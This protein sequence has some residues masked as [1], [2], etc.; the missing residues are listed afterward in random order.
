MGR[1]NPTLL[2]AFVLGAGIALLGTSLQAQQG[3]VETP[4][5]EQ[6]YLI[7]QPLAQFP[8]KSVVVFTGQFAPGASTPLH[9]HPGTE[10]LYVLEGRGEMIRP[11]RE[12]IPLTPG[13]VVLAEPDPGEAAFTHLARN[14]S[15]SAPMKT[16]V[17]VIH[18]EGG[19]TALPIEE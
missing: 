5:V 15:D 11:G 3:R 18:D 7:R 1:S 13:S 12:P 19:P 4:G 6:E 17:I 16:L 2:F 8:G 10:F 14:L 9:K